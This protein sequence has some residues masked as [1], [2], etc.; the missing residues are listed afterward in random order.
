MGKVFAALAWLWGKL[1]IVLGVVWGPADPPA[2]PPEPRRM[3]EGLE[4]RGLMSAAPLVL[5]LP[6]ALPPATVIR[7]TLAPEKTPSAP[8]Q[9]PGLARNSTPRL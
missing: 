5:A 6:L 9:H 7:P 8:G 1:R 4:D 2:R 3:I